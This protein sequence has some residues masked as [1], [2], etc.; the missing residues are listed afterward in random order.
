MVSF[1]KTKEITK[2]TTAP[3]WFLDSG[4]G[5]DLFW[6]EGG[7]IVFFAYWAYRNVPPFTWIPVL[8]GSKSHEKR[9]GYQ[10]THNVKNKAPPRIPILPAFPGADN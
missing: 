3:K 4:Q 9:P 1:L 7:Y 6:G 2:P 8:D 5:G 10:Q